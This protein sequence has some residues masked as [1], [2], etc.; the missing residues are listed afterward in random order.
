MFDVLVSSAVRSESWL[1]VH[2][3]SAERWGSMIL[4]ARDVL[5]ENV[6]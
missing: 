2:G 1:D 4:P 6:V 5:N 3:S